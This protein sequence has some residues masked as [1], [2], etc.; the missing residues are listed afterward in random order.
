MSDHREV[1]LAEAKRIAAKF[2]VK[3]PRVGYEMS[4]GSGMWLV[5]TGHFQFG[6]F[7]SKEKHP[8]EVRC[9]CYE[10]LRHGEPRG[11]LVTC[12]VLAE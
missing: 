12:P 6:W 1:S 3:L 9:R 11:H 8:F 10:T 4:L 2:N 5:S 7:E